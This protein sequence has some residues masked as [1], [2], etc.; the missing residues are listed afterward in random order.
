MKDASTE[1]D[2]VQMVILLSGQIWLLTPLRQ[3]V[4]V[5]VNVSPGNTCPGI[6]I[7]LIFVILFPEF[8]NRF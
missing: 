2:R 6:L 8:L 1:A 7:Q 3:K 5:K 4:Q